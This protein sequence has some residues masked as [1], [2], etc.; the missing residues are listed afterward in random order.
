MRVVIEPS[1]SEM[2]DTLAVRLALIEGAQRGWSGEIAQLEDENRRLREAMG[3]RA[4]PNAFQWV[5]GN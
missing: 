2:A 4:I 3:Q 1:T 5:D